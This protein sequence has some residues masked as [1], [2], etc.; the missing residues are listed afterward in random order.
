MDSLDYDIEIIMVIIKELNIFDK[1][2]LLY[3]CEEKFYFSGDI[4][5]EI[6]RS[7]YEINRKAR[8]TKSSQYIKKIEK[9]LIKMASININYTQYGRTVFLNGLFD[10]KF[11]KLNTRTLRVKIFVNIFFMN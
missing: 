2:L 9:S 6:D 4:N 10:I 7:I 3:I 8:L 5:F 11:Y 1:R